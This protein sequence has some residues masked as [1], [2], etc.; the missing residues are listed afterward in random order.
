MINNKNQ[1]TNVTYTP[2]D[3]HH[4]LLSPGVSSDKDVNIMMKI[5]NFCPRH[6][7]FSWPS[8]LTAVRAYLS[9]LQERYFKIGKF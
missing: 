9:L 2:N 3:V 5:H 4:E 8:F 1:K 7:S 6:L